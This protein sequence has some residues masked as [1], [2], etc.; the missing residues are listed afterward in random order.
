MSEEQ[1]DH[2]AWSMLNQW[3]ILSTLMAT[4]VG[5]FP[6][7]SSDAEIA[8]KDLPYDNHGFFHL[9]TM[10]LLFSW[11]APDATNKI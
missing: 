6:N 2:N 1:R 7:G 11:N 5:A 3:L 4:A 9:A 8:K 10:P